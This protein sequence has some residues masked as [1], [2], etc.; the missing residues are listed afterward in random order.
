LF[1]PALK[2]RHARCAFDIATISGAQLPGADP[3]K[4]V[5]FEREHNLPI[6]LHV[7]DG[8]AFGVG[9]VERFVELSNVRLSVVS[10]FAVGIGMMH[11]ADE[12]RAFTCSSP[13]QMV[14][15][16]GVSEGVGLGGAR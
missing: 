1:A 10:P 12:A 6:E 9:L 8:P 7:D 15:A 16:I 14:V 4:G 2:I 11:D 3:S 5:A 13:L